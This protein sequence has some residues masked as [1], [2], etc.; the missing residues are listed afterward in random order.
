MRLNF[1]EDL[2]MAAILEKKKLNKYYRTNYAKS[3]WNRRTMVGDKVAKRQLAGQPSTTLE[4]WER[5]TEC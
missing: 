1:P 2:L 4:G 3:K 5:A